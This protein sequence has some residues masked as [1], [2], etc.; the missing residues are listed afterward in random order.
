MI[1]II[2]NVKKLNDD[3]VEIT[4]EYLYTDF[5]N[6][7]PYN[8]EKIIISRQVKKQEDP[9]FISFYE[10]N[11]KKM[12]TS[13]TNDSQFSKVVKFKAYRNANELLFF[14]NIFHYKMILEMNNY[15]RMLNKLPEKKHFKKENILY[16]EFIK[17]LI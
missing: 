1:P 6:E 10:D 15:Y 14:Q 8:K 2:T 4:R 3:Q 9:L 7:K 12:V 17:N 13:I 16:H 5:Y 11:L